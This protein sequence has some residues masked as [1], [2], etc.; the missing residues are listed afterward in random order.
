MPKAP[1]PMSPVL[2]SDQAVPLNT[3]LLVCPGKPVPVSCELSS[4][5]V[6]EETTSPLIIKPNEPQPGWYLDHETAW[7]GRAGLARALLLQ[8]R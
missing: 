7:G 2:L 3:Q 6:S 1:R 5:Q 8:Q 4:L